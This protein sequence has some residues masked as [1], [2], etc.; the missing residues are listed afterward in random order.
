M[1]YMVCMNV[2][3]CVCVYV[4]TYVCMYICMYIRMGICMYI[5]MGTNKLNSTQRVHKQSRHGSVWRHTVA[6]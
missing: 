6:L 1:K 2:C 4:C 3:V 5:R